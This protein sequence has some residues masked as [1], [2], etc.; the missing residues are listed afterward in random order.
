MHVR[1]NLGG[2]FAA[3]EQLYDALYQWNKAGG[4]N[5]TTT[6]L[7]FFTQLVSTTTAQN[8][9]STSAGYASLVSAVT[10][11]ADGFVS[12]VQTYTPSG[13]QLSEQYLKTTGAQ[14]SA[15]QL[16]WSFAAA[17]SAFDAKSNFVP[18]SWGAKGLTTSCGGGSSGGGTVAVTFNEVA[19][20]VW[21]E[22][23]YIVGSIPGESSLSRLGRLER[24]TVSI[25][26]T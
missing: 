20:T 10:A 12:L 6:S 25:L 23:I 16:T 13:G 8:Y 2:R 15:A 26:R 1:A 22:N 5:V 21:G 4:I 3:A 7:P 18:A 19:T 9:A 17:V 14:T 11:Y 24:L